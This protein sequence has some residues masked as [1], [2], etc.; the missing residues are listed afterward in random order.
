EEYLPDAG[1][2]RYARIGRDQLRMLA[3]RS[4]AGVADSNYNRKEMLDAGFRRVSVLPPRTDF[5]ALKR[6]PDEPHWW[7]TNHWVFVGGRVVENKCQHDLIR[8]FAA[9]ARSYHPTARLLLVGDASNGP[10]VSFLR[11]EAETLGVADRVDFKGKLSPSDL[12]LAYRIS[13]LFVCLSE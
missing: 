10:Y 9:Y 5:S 11:R 8:A 13:G 7:R 1:L 6:K 12:L 3:G 2:R 4:E